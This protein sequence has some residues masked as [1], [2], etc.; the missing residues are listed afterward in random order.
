MPYSIET[1]DGITIDNIPD[2][3]E[4]DSDVLRQRVAEERAKRDGGDL[5][6]AQAEEQLPAGEGGKLG[7]ALTLGSA[8][9]TEP[10]A[11]IAG[12]AQSINPFADE[13]AGAQAVAG[14]KEALTR[15]P[16]TQ[17]EVESL[18]TVGEL[19]KK[20]VDLV[21]FPISGLAGL[22]E[23]VAGQGLD[24]AAETLKN[25]Q[26]QGLGKTLGER[27]LEA[28]DSPLA[29]TVARTAPTALMMA[30]PFVAKA[31]KGH[32]A[33]PKP[34]A[35]KPT[36]K[37]P[38]SEI[39]RYLDPTKKQMI[40]MIKKGEAE[41]TVATKMVNGAGKLKTHKPSKEAVTQGYDEGVISLI[42]TA[43]RADKVKY[44]K[45]LKKVSRGL[46]DKKIAA[47]TRPGD[48]AGSSLMRRWQA[49]SGINKRAGKSI[50]NIVKTELAGKQ[51]N[52]QK[53]ATD[54]MQKLQKEGIRF[55]PETSQ[56]ILKGSSMEGSG[57]A[58]RALNMVFKR[59][60]GSMDG[61]KAHELKRFIDKQVTWGKNREGGLDADAER[62]LKGLRESI[63]TSLKSESKKYAAANNTFAESKGA[64][65]LMQQATGK[66]FDPLSG[67]ANKIMGQMS[68]RLIGNQVSRVQIMDSIQQMEKIA[69]KNGVKFNDDILSQAIFVSELERR[70][71]S[72]VAAGSF[73]GEITTAQETALRAAAGQ[74]T[75]A[76]M[77]VKLGKAGLEKA[78]GINDKNAIKAM[79]ELIKSK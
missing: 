20:G 77:A 71:P 35:A 18:K 56:L 52:T 51:I 24:Q 70:F 30:A 8:I 21:N 1:K 34:T 63:N 15:K 27:T 12:I 31:M 55:D 49:V 6:T 4:P 9:A 32:L 64:L 7:A 60:G 75:V 29:A 37:P 39:F 72:A 28:T 22:G 44:G 41:S 11:G 74:E 40:E 23:L 43:S 46:T 58:K 62:I 19:M 69:A 13:G 53:A 73:K 54:F 79:H 45:M 33:T 3:I 65:E 38:E 66:K 78:Q 14:T 16:K 5:S 25:V 67:N 68:R 42:N 57:T 2:D 50:D 47:G 10:L 59:V 36:P 61:K 17:A 26:A 48:V 76:G